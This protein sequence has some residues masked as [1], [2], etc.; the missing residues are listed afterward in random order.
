[1]PIIDGL[2]LAHQAIESTGAIVYLLTSYEDFDYAKKGVKI[3]VEDYILKNELS[4]NLLRGI[5]DRAKEK[6]A[7]KRE[8]KCIFRVISPLF[9][10][11]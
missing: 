1:M 9:T 6:I 2:E 10:A 4:E 3:G 5:L 11:N 7:Q 8:E